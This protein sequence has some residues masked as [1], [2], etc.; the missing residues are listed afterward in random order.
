MTTDATPSTEL[1][2]QFKQAH[3]LS[4][5]MIGE[6]LQIPEPSL[7]KMEKQIDMY[8]SM[9][10]SHIEAM[11]GKLEVTVTLPAGKIHVSS[12]AEPQ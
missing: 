8:L 5:K 11:G 2:A 1:Q 9:L 10:R 7:G 12:L 6:V 4:R 3:G